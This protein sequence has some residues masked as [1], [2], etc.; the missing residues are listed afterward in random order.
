MN[1]GKS[2]GAGQEEE[3]KKDKEQAGLD[4]LE[5]LLRDHPGCG[6]RG[7]LDFFSPSARPRSQTAWII[8]EGDRRH[9]LMLREALGSSGWVGD[10]PQR[11]EG[12]PSAVQPVGVGERPAAIVLIV[13]FGQRRGRPVS[14]FIVSR[15]RERD[16]PRPSRF[17]PRGN[18]GC[19]R[20]P[21]RPRR[22]LPAA[23]PSVQSAKETSLRRATYNRTGAQ[24]WRVGSLTA[25]R[26]TQ[27]P[28]AGGARELRFKCRAAT[29]SW[30]WGRRR[31]V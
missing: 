20:S 26:T 22:Q 18:A 3:E 6:A 17:G 14:C 31:K 19:G 28:Y 7:G 16:D 27:D 5:G 29:S 23:F 10:I 21:F 24:L 2:G 1:G 11:R 9:R 4:D 12:R 8:W 13:I 30:R 15:S 25:M